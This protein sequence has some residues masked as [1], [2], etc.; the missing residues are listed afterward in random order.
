MTSTLM[1]YILGEMDYPPEGNTDRPFIVRDDDKLSL[2][3]SHIAIQSQMQQDAPDA[4]T[5]AYT[6]TMMGFLLFQPAP[7]RIAMIGLGGGSLAKYCYRYLPDAHFTAV[8]VNPKILDF[9]AL[10]QI[11]QDGSRFTVLCADGASYVGSDAAAVDVLLVDGFEAL[12]TPPQLCSQRFYDDCYAKLND[13]GVMV[14]NFWGRDPDYPTCASRIH[15]SFYG[16]AL[17][18]TAD[19]LTNRVVFAC[20]KGCFPPDESVLM[21]RVVEPAIEH[22]V[23]LRMTARKI[24]DRLRLPETSRLSGNPDARPSTDIS[25]RNRPRMALSE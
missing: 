23:R 3:F 4:L 17:A 15:Q 11:P 8:E 16:Q 10:F 19:R 18:V 13:G 6:R 2:H 21:A 1:K 22:P 14:V 24:R 20:K 25:T 9:R 5:L 12:A 7:K